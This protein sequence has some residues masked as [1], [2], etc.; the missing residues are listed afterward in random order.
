M[1]LEANISFQFPIILKYIQ[2]FFPFDRYTEETNK[3]HWTTFLRIIFNFI[4]WFLVCSV[5]W[6]FLAKDEKKKDIKIISRKSKESNINFNEGKIVAKTS[7]IHFFFICSRCSMLIQNF[8]GLFFL[9]LNFLWM[10]FCDVCDASIHT[11]F[12]RM[13]RHKKEWNE[14][15]QFYFIYFNCTQYIRPTTMAMAVTMSI[16]S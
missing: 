13:K 11:K 15:K 6:F 16:R 2:L 7:K 9:V 5:K 12:G 3:K 1:V 10:N 4:I 8:K 14:S